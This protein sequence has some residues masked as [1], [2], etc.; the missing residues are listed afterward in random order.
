M[1]LPDP[2]STIFLDP[3]DK[4]DFSRRLENILKQIE[5][6][7]NGFIEYIEEI[8]ESENKITIDFSDLDE[9]FEKL[10]KNALGTGNYENLIKLMQQFLL[11]GNSENAKKTWSFL[12]QSLAQFN[13]TG[14]NGIFLIFSGF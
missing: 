3:E 6:F 8:D 7:E 13:G 12:V 5:I 14:K 4:E 11:L 9:I 1:K 10:K 2:S